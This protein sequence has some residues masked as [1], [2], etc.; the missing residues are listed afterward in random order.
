MEN[1]VI[2]INSQDVKFEMVESH[3]MTD[4]LTLAKVF[5]KEHKNVLAAIKAK[6]DLFRGQLNFQ[7]SS[8][9][10]GQ[11]KEQPMYLLDRDFFSFIVMGFTGSRADKWKL[12]YIKA[13]NIME[14]RLNK[15]MTQ[16]EMVIAS[17]KVLQ[18]QEARLTTLEHKVDNITVSKEILPN[19]NF[20]SIDELHR[21][22]KLSRNVIKMIL[23]IVEPKTV[24]AVKQ[25]PD[26]SAAPYTAYKIKPV[27]KF[28]K[29]VRA[30]A[31]PINAKAIF[32]R[33]KLLGDKKFQM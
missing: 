9:I 2:V 31:K 24:N 28:A 22:T 13:F 14:E 30:T 23:D 7:P 4:S 33:S 19:A 32:Y 27:V 6:E 18:E 16:L 5:G 26:G 25:L 15:P 17:A 11:N 3:Y 1:N 10:N 20:A 12:Q 21:R 29:K 8:Y